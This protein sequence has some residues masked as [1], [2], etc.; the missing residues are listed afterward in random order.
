MDEPEKKK[1]HHVLIDQK[2]IKKNEE[3]T[4]SVCTDGKHISL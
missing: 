3:E 2:L 1:D 4:Q